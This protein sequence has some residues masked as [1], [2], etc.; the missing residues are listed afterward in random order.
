MA[1]LVDDA[2]AVLDVAVLQLALRGEAPAGLL[3]PA[4]VEHVRDPLGERPRVGH[5]DRD[6]GMPDSIASRSGWSTAFW[7]R[8]EAKMPSGLAAIAWFSRST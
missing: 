3:V 2:D 1:R 5:V 6:H 4:H 7:S 8:I